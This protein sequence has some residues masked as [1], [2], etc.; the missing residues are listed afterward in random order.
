M[1]E[2]CA[3]ADDIG[4]LRGTQNGILQEGLAEP[5]P[6][7]AQVHSQTGKQDHGD[8]ILSQ[9][10]RDALRCVFAADR[11]GGKRVV[12]D[13]ACIARRRRSARNGSGGSRRRIFGGTR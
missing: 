13:D 12:T 11:T 2:N 7:L 10:V 3:A 1:R 8:G 6:A 5:F 9:T 4:S